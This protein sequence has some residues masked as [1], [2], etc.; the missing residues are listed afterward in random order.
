M[1]KF[2]IRC[3]YCNSPAILRPAGTV[4]GRNVKTKGSHLYVCSHWPECDAYVAAHKSDNRPMGTLAN[5]D[6]RHKR[7]LAHKAMEEYRAKPRMDKWGLY[8]W[9]Q[10]KLN[11]DSRHAHVGMFTEEQ[12]DRVMFEC[13]KALENLSGEGGGRE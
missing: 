12:C 6:L 4:Y 3:P 1:K 11:L 10:G 9:L 13:K 8:L 5:G 7:I 2:N